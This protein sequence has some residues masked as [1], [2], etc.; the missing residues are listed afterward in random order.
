MRDP[1]N[2]GAIRSNATS[3]KIM[4]DARSVPGRISPALFFL[5]SML[6]GNDAQ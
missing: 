2:T 1:L 4:L 3:T 6:S 5:V